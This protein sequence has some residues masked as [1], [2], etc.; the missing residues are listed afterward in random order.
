VI[1]TQRD[2]GESRP[3]DTHDLA[4]IF[5]TAHAEKAS[6]THQPIRPDTAEEDLME[7][8]F[9]L[10]RSHETVHLIEVRP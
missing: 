7:S 2:E 9:D 1:E 3:P 10:L 4:N 5:P 6:Q 8:W